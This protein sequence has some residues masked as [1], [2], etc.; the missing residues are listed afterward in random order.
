MLKPE[1]YMDPSISVISISA[2]IILILKKTQIAKYSDLV[3]MI[4]KSKGEKARTN[5]LSS[6]NFLFL[7]DK[8]DYFNE[9][10]KIIL[11]TYEVI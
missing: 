3:D 1:K 8:I 5:F 2:E 6:I 9:A 10:D 11:K 7:L 4:I